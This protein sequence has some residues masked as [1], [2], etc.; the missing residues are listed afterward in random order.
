M[1]NFNDTYDENRVIY[2]I[3]G[4][5]WRAEFF[6]RIA[7]ELPNRFK[8]C[9]LVTRSEEKKKKISEAWGINTYSSIDELLRFNK[10]N[11]VV[12]SVAGFIAPEIITEL[13]IKGIPVLAETPPAPD[14]EGLIKLNKL[15]EIGAKIQVAEQYHLQPLHAARISI[16]ASGKLGEISQAYVS[17]S[18]GYHGMSLMRK[19]LGIGF[20]NAKINGYEFISPI[21]AGPGRGGLPLEE[22]LID[23]QQEFAL[24]DF[25]EKLGIYDFAKDQ[26]RSYIRSQR[27]LVRGTKGE[28]NNKEVKYLKDFR[29]PIE[30][31]LIQKHTGLFGDVEDYYIK[32]ILAGDEW[33]YNNPFIPGKLSE[34]EI[35]VA[36]CLENMDA[37]VKEGKEFYSLAEASQDQYLALMI[38]K[39]IFSR[40]TVI[41]ETQPWAL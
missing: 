34:D 21:I 10:P 39:A 19:L 36:S 29:T 31:E 20:E 5:G 4:S 28:I 35:A 41:T 14:L 17:F 13:S 38:K 26:H 23:I 27:I 15:K 16:A 25:G 11:F 40:S 1:N 18:H 33:V 32:G 7:K 6:L 12:V 3:V 2:G 8:V 24:I 37:Y 9:G 22:N 30:Y